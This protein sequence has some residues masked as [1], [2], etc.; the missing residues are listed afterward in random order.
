VG[1]RWRGDPLRIKQ[2]LLNL[3]GNA[4]KFTLQGGV[5]VMIARQAAGPTCDRL[6]F[7]VRDTGIGFDEETRARL[8]NRFTQADRETARRFG[9][10]GLGLSICR[11][12]VALMG[13]EID[14]RSAPGQGSEFWFSAPFPRVEQSNKAGV[15]EP[16]AQTGGAGRRLRVL[17][18]DDHPVNRQ[19]LAQTL[20]HFGCAAQFAENGAEAVATWEADAFD[21]I[22][23]DLLMPVLSGVEAA[24]TIRA[25]EAATGRARTPILALSANAGA[26]QAAACRAAGM[27][28]HVAKPFQPRLLAAAMREALG[29]AVTEGA[30]KAR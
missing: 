25:R 28:G 23:M 6:S 5:D 11:G 20:A 27:D 14:C 13:G 17:C 29:E 2:V 8:F 22:I 19:V 12:L 1:G 15:D 24:K 4:V 16:D 7:T 30:H 18:V 3:I 9:G 21:L 10:T 26:D